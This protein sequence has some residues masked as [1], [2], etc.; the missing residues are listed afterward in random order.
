MKTV[1]PDAPVTGWE[2]LVPTIELPTTGTWSPPPWPAEP[3]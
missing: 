3:T 2:R 1:F